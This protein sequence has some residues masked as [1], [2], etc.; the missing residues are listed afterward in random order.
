MSLTRSGRRRPIATR[1]KVLTGLASGILDCMKARV[2]WL[3]GLKFEAMGD[4]ARKVVIDAGDIMEGKAGP[5][6]MEMVLMAAGACTASDIVY[7]LQKMREKV[8]RLEVRLTADR[9]KIEPKV[10]TKLHCEY[11]VKGHSLKETSVRRALRLT[12]EK[13]CSVQIMLRRAGV[14]VTTS[15]SISEDAALHNSQ[16]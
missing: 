12:Q 3:E 13:Y 5:G 7:I 11:I 15:L 6:P 8:T 14:L 10:F 1:S 2:S 16:S 9:S 4:S